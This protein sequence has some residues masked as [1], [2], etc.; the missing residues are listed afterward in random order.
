MKEPEGSGHRA[1][2]ADE[3]PSDFG[4]DERGERG[5]VCRGRGPDTGE[6]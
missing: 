4:V 1:G 5:G 6:P 2:V 3:Q